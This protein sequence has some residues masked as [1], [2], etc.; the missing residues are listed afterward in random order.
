[1]ARDCSPEI[2]HDRRTILWILKAE[3]RS[4]RRGQFS[5]AVRAI[6]CLCRSVVEAS[7]TQE[8]STLPAAWHEI[9]SAPYRVR[10]PDSPRR[11]RAQCTT[12]PAPGRSARGTVS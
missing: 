3:A 11:A 1:M 9:G 10:Y 7:A 5:R 2:S 8:N 6:E 12:E 4:K